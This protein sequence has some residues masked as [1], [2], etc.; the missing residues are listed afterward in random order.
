MFAHVHGTGASYYA[1]SGAWYK[2]AKQ[3]DVD[4]KAPLASP[5]FTGT[6][7]VNDLTIGGT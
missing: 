6:A 3:T 1:H 7:N 4:L 2:L 5:T